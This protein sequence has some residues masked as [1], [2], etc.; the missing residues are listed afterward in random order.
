MTRI[1]IPILLLISIMQMNANDTTTLHYLKREPKDIT[2]KTP[3]IILLH[4]VGSNEE[5][6]FSLVNQLPDK[7]LV[8]SARAP[9]PLNSNSFAWYQV[10]FSKG[11]PVYDYNE[12]EK[13]RFTIIKFIED[14]KKKYALDSNEIFLLGFSQGAIM[15]YSVALTRPDLIKGMVAI[16][17]RLL[18]EIKPKV[19]DDTKI[20]N[21]NLFIVH[22]KND[23]VLSI[24][25]ARN[26]NEFLKTKIYNTFLKEYNAGHEITNEML[27]N[28]I[29][30]LK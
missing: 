7:Y 30:W 5:D 11:R 28:I 10:D 14:L 20:K 3:I 2:S 21:L 24:D 4:G 1:I 23:N 9:I 8:I 13:S 6:L 27:L 17:G 16:S 25:Y 15:S 29:D 22:G 12:A 19:V 26:A 18:E